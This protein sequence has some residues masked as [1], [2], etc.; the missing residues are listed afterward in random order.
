MTVGS[1]SLVIPSWALAPGASAP[2]AA[3]VQPARAG[4]R[5][6]AAARALASVASAR[7]DSAEATSALQ[8]MARGCA[9]LAA[10][11]SLDSAVTSILVEQSRQTDQRGALA[12]TDVLRKLGDLRQQHLREQEAIKKRQEAERSSGILSKLINFFKGLAAALAAASSIFTGPA[13]IAAAA[14]MIASIIVSCAAPESW[15][16][17]VSLGLSVAGAL[18]G[19]ASGLLGETAKGA[20]KIAATTLKTIA[21]GMTVADGTTTVAK[22][23]VDSRAVDARATLL[24]IDATCKKLLAD[25]EEQREEMKLCVEAQDRGVKAVCRALDGDHSAAMAALRGR[26]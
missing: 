6:A 4:V 24:E 11:G 10:A 3:L 26:R 23:V 9:A 1:I 14:L 8:K 12:K 15:G 17:W 16:K 18:C 25:A 13:G 7:L 5:A 21:S 2:G 19:G 20:V 22:G